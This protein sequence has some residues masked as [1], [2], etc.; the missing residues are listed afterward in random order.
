[1]WGIQELLSCG[2]L[3]LFFKTPFSSC[4]SVLPVL[5]DKQLSGKIGWRW[6]RKS[7]RPCDL[8]LHW[9]KLNRNLHLSKLQN[10]FAWIIKCIC[11]NYQMYLWMDVT[12]KIELALRPN[13][14]LDP[15]KIG[16]ENGQ[17]LDWDSVKVKSDIF[18]SSDSFPLDWLVRQGTFF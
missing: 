9:T 18:S 3:E 15:V 8:T 5:F 2:G 17:I 4:S 14:T 10:I 7:D 12:E 16:Q 6:P 13:I 11:P 1:M